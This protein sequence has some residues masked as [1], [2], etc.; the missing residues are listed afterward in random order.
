[1][2]KVAFVLK[3]YPRVSET[4]IA[5]E[6]HLLEQRG[7]NIEILSMRDA[8]E[9]ERQPIVDLIRAPVT[10]LPE[11]LWP[12]AGT[13]LWENLK[14]FLMHPASYP[15]WFSIALWRSLR[16]RNH[17]P[18]K[19]FLQA[20]W[21]TARRNIGRA[22]D[23][24][25]HLHAH[26]AHTPTELTL[27]LSGIT[28]LPFSISAHAKDI[29]TLPPAELAERVNASRLIMTCTEFNWQFLRN[30]PGVQAGKI[31]RVYHG[32]NLDLFK[33]DQPLPQGGAF[34]DGLRRFVSVGRLVEKKGYDIVLAALHRIKI[35]GIRFTYDIYGA[36]ELDHELLALTKE[37]GLEDE[38]RFHRTAT[39]PQ[40]IAR[41]NE[42][43]MYLGG[44]KVTANG[45][46]DGIPNT[47][48][49]A[50]SMEM[51]VL[52]TDV[53]GIPELIEHGKSGH[54]VPPNDAGAFAA[55]L[56][57]MLARPEY[58]RALGAQARERVSKVFNCECC[59][60]SCAGLLRPLLAE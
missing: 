30:L 24:I 12:Q 44:F 48:A 1:M 28:G 5:Q 36:G 8:R 33:R 20:G 35:R 45:D 19:R 46:R 38:V 31:H 13:V 57:A 18:M 17:G 51:P 58:C 9:R 11:Y 53:S 41:M 50:M 10:Y 39:H 14:S 23:G 7:F 16:R 29:Y 37:L 40:I 15:R 43:G 4:F 49:E 42:G 54:L 25:R 6:I 21:V 60:E 55:A 22:S 59:I 47:I 2:K 27:Y 32:I 56:E 26:F 52:A 34:A 3:G